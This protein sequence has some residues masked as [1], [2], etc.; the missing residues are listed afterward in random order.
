[1]LELGQ[2][3]SGSQTGNAAADYA[4]RLTPSVLVVARQDRATEE[5]RR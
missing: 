3:K 5:L 4:Y 1:M 2:F